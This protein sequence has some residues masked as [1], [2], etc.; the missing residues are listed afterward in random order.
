MQALCNRYP[1]RSVG[2]KGNRFSTDYFNR[3]LNEL[4]W[5]TR[6]QEFDALNWE[7]S[8]ARLESGGRTFELL[9][10]PYSAGCDVISEMLAVDTVEKLSETEIGEKIVLLYGPIAREQLMP[11]NFVFYNPAKHQHIIRLLEQKK[12]AAIISATGRSE[13]A[14]GTYPFPLIEDGDFKIP[15]V[16]TTE[17]TGRELL[18]EVHKTARLISQSTLIPEK[19]YNIIGQK[20]PKEAQRLV[21][22]AHIDTKKGT[23]GAI[24]NATGVTILLRLAAL[25]ADYQ[26]PYR[27][28]IV[29]LNGEDYY[30]VPGQMQYIRENQGFFDQIALNINIDGAGYKSGPTA[31]SRYGVPADMAKAVDKVVA[32]FDGLA[33]G[34]PWPQG[35]H[36]IFIQYGCPALAVTSEWLITHL[37]EQNFTHTPKDTLALVDPEKLEETARALA[38]LKK[39]LPTPN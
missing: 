1:D 6:S 13:M 24:D 30:S 14:G 2:S 38:D 29:A 4:G 20:G 28:E 10:S 8:G 18:D 33:H 22:T 9:V 3:V 32:G 16:Y 21:I 34:D 26:G 19:G 35:D 11:K 25:L 27:L 37:E 7:G 36:S 31:I 17:E 23:P 5:Q 12:P 15:S 39:T